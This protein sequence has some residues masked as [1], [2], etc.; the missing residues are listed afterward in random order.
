MTVQLLLIRHLNITL[1][2]KAANLQQ[3]QRGQSIKNIFAKAGDPIRVQ[4]PLK[5]RMATFQLQRPPNQ[6]CA[7]A[8]STAD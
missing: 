2:T 5:T 1:I 3:C 6:S 7:G 4:Q 8:V